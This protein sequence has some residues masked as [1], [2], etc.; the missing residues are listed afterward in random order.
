MISNL[1]AASINTGTSTST[2]TSTKL[3]LVLVLVLVLE[4]VLV[5]VLVT[6]MCALEN[7]T[8]KIGTFQTPAPQCN[9]ESC[10]DVAARLEDPRCPKAIVKAIQSFGKAAV[11]TDNAITRE[12]A[13][14]SITVS[15]RKDRVV[16]RGMQS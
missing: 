12:R 9:S 5:L 7:D 3:V 4:I 13:T 2:S 6:L 16:V 10:H 11:N 8:T 1:S 15:G 14:V